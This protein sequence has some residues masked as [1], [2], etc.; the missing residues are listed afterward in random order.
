MAYTLDSGDEQLIRKLGRLILSAD[1][2]TFE[3]D[4]PDAVIGAAI[5]LIEEQLS[6][7]FPMS[8]EM[9]DKEADEA[10]DWKGMDGAIAYHLIDRHA[11]NW[12]EISAMMNAWLRAN[13]GNSG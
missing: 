9:T 4:P 13:S 8:S 7:R 11:E 5:N 1:G 6:D 12:N 10:Q 2:G 3:N